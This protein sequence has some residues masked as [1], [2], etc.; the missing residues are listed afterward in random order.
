MV[1][2]KEMNEARRRDEGGQR[3]GWPHSMKQPR[4]YLWGLA[5]SSVKHWKCPKRSISFPGVALGNYTQLC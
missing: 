4:L 1:L 2:W 5:E 3:S